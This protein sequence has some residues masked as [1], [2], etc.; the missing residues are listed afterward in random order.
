MMRVGHRWEYNKSLC[1]DRRAS[2]MHVSGRFINIKE[3]ADVGGSDVTG[4]MWLLCGQPGSGNGGG[5]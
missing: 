1:D 5:S 4:R 2:A 3:V